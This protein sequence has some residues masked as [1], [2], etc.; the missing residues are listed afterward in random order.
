MFSIQL[1]LPKEYRELNYYIGKSNSADGDSG[2]PLYIVRS[3]L[4]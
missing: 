2:S 3:K 1:G 4:S